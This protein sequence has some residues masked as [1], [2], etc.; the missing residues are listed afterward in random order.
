MGEMH[1]NEGSIKVNGLISYVPQ[2][3][4]ICN[5]TIR[6]NILFGEEYD[7]KRYNKVIEA[8]SMIKDLQNFPDGDMALVG[9]RGVSLSGG[10]KARLCCARALYAD[11]DIVLMD[12]PL[13]A[14]DAIVDRQL[15]NSWFNSTDGILRGKTVLLVTHA[16]HHLSRNEIDNIIYLKEGKVANQGSYD[17]LMSLKG[18]FSEMVER[19]ATQDNQATEEE[20]TSKEP[21]S[22][23]FGKESKGTTQKEKKEEGTVNFQVYMYYIKSCGVI[24]F[25]IFILNALLVLTLS[26]GII[27]YLVA[28]R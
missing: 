2:R 14:V 17:S 27:Y 19:S 4:W 1:S 10:Q 11:A 7:E 18:D 6:E 9:A 8:C 13:S 5:G 12:D 3:A 23:D 15:F 25:S 26:N 24:G 21:T 28:T 16:V 20:M 22:E